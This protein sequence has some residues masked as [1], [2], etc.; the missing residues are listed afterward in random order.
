MAPAVPPAALLRM[1][2]LIID[3]RH[4]NRDETDMIMAKIRDM[5]PGGRRQDGGWGS[6][7]I[8]VIVSD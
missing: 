3:L 1:T 6:S 8:A 2:R 5:R 7:S 4:K